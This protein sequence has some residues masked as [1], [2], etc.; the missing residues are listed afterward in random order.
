M[1]HTTAVGAK[2]AN[3]EVVASKPENLVGNQ[4]DTRKNPQVIDAGFGQD[5]PASC[6]YITL[7]VISMMS[8]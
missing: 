6:W 1:S 4:Q 7:T 8:Q 5:L 3:V 2:L